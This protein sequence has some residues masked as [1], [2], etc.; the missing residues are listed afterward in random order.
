M[1]QNLTF[2]IVM[3][4]SFVAQTAITAAAEL[5][6]KPNI[7]FILADDLGLMDIGYN[8]PR[9]VYTPTLDKLASE[10]AIFDRSYSMPQCTPTRVALL[11]GRFPNRFG[12]RQLIANNETNL[13]PGTSTIAS[14]LKAQGYSTHLAGKW[15]IATDIAAGPNHFGFD[16]SYGSLAGAVGAYDH[17]YRVG[18][19]ALTWHR[20]LTIIPGNEDG[21]HVTD[22]VAREAVRIIENSRQPFFL[23]LPFHTPHTPLDERGK[24]TDSPTQLD[25]KNPKRWLNEDDIPWFNDPAGIIQKEPDP[26]KRLLLAAVHH[27]DHAVGEVIAALDRV[28]LRKNTLIVFTSDNGPQVKW[29]GNAYPDDLKLT[30]FNQPLPLRG[31]KMEVWEGGIHVPGFANWPGHIAPKRIKEPIHIIDW[32]PS[33]L[34]VAGATPEA[35]LQVDG[36]NV[37][38]ALFEKNSTAIPAKRELHWMWGNPPNRRALSQGE[39]KIVRYGTGEPKTASEWQLFNLTAD[40]KEQTNVAAQHPA[41]LESL[42]QAYLTQ[43]AKDK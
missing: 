28:D 25:P 12:M 11:T 43:R 15:H 20:D 13:P 33:L 27:L 34:A 23:Y 2:F 14:L 6:Q 18:A 3:F 17:R 26:Q 37:A 5:P 38:P 29:S 24:F 4:S 21:V 32:L 31:S 36:I 7:I 1:K 30:N 22:L 40:P 35:A 16:S 9:K 19:N 39:W 42:H 41:L 10:G 8:N